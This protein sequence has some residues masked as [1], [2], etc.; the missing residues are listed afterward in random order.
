MIQNVKKILAPIEFSEYSMQALKGAWELARDV[1]AE[2]HLLHV[3]VPE[4]NFLPLFLAR[5][6]ESA[7]EMARE[8]AL[9]EQA[10]EELRQ[11]KKD[12]LEN[13]NK[14][15][16]ASAIGAP[17]PEI[18]KYAKEQNIDLIVLSTHGRTG[19]GHA[20]IGHVAE[21]LVRQTSSSVLV[22]RARQA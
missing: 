19:I 22:L 10:D 13:S 11:I 2:L 3:V 9:S 15:K 12:Q 17:V 21:K 1:G 8:A 18:D 4:H 16:V 5:D 6:A 14:V 7:R 20:L